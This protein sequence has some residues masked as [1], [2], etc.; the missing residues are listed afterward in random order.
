MGKQ[1]R[2]DKHQWGKEA[3]LIADAF[4]QRKRVKTLRVAQE[5]AEANG[6]LPANA[7]TI[8]SDS[9]L[10]DNPNDVPS[11]PDADQNGGEDVPKGSDEPKKTQVKLS[12]IP[13]PSK[14]E[15]RAMK[16]EKKTLKR[17][18][19][20]Y[21]KAKHAN[22]HKGLEDPYKKMEEM[23]AA[24]GPDG[25]RDVAKMRRKAKRKEERESWKKQMDEQMQQKLALL[26][27]DEQAGARKQDKNE[28]S[29]DD[30][31]S[32]GSGGVPI[33]HP[34]INKQSAREIQQRSD[35]ISSGGTH[36]ED[37]SDSEDGD[38][39]DSGEDNE[40]GIGEDKGTSGVDEDDS[41]ISAK[42]AK[43]L[44]SMY[45]EHPSLMATSQEQIDEYLTENLITIT[46]SPSHAKF[47]PSTKFAHLPF[48]D[49]AH[50]TIFAQF[51]DPTPI[52]AAAWPYALSG[53]D[54]IGIA[55]T[56]SGKTLA[57]GSP[58]VRHISSIPTQGKR[59]GIRAV[60]ITPTREL[61]CQIFEYMKKLG[62]ACKLGVVCLYGGV[63][64]EEQRTD[65]K[66]AH[67]VVA[68]PGRLQDL[69]DEGAADMSRVSYLVL[70]EADRM[71]EKGFDEAIKRIIKTMPK[72]GNER[73]T[74]MFTATWPPTVRKLAATFMTDPVR[75]GIGDNPEG[76]LRANNRI[77]Q[78]VEVVLPSQ[79][80]LRLLQILKRN[81]RGEGQDR[82]LVFCL[83]KKEAFKVEV[84]LKRKDFRV[85]S[86]HGDL[87]QQ[88]RTANLQA[89]KD[90]YVPILIAT[91]VASRGLDIPNV[92]L[93]VNMTFP[94]TV[95]D[96][97]HR[98]GRTGRAGKSG[99]AITLF[100]MHDK[101]LAGE[102]IN[103]LKKA[104]QKV[105][106]EL[107]KFGTTVKKKQHEAYGNF[108]KDPSEM[109]QATKI[110]FDD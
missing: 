8:D 108:Y 76:E 34:P 44:G 103:V 7:T 22:R 14:E 4:V 61:A 90:G 58:C 110:T 68:T 97:V 3:E 17:E 84:F 6:A 67:I 36:D 85:V 96:Y 69:I 26:N 42:A 16:K 25:E 11:Q 30:S 71:L 83:Y 49:G 72:S 70:D 28:E 89:F 33:Y 60:I 92:N 86:I 48:T 1:K 13:K 23:M 78:S 50:R 38:E 47:R 18:L 27:G 74:L 12:Y 101:H 99:L 41:P 31:D 62:S 93:V 29:E 10:L 56:G 104:N 65:L 109:K 35:S 106:P 15:R 53:R 75:I 45:V 66:S 105:P 37:E 82:F 64:K 51:R 32:D 107:L 63:P 21:N 91:D 20:E 19:K 46:D 43:I 52:Q 9:K 100:S 57:Y 39:N 87:N 79:K 98:I 80:Q 102:L 95:E 24:L 94:L 55:E 54:V 2:K 73:Q 59:S 5:Q 40:I 88:Q 81:M 77:T